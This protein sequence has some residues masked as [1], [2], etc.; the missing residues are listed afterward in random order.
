M[1]LDGIPLR[2]V[3]TAGIRESQDPVEAI[4]VE[5]ALEAARQSDLVLFLL[6]GSAE[7]TKEDQEIL[8]AL[9]D[10]PCIIVRRTEG[11]YLPDGLGRKGRSF[12][13][14]ISG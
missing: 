9:Q 3:D 14:C 7:A 10:K 6:E 1:N 2:L 12:G 13:W 5:R 11:T 8:Q 4:G